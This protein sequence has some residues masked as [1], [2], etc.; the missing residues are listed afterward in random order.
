MNR[1]KLTDRVRAFIDG[2]SGETFDELA[3]AIFREQAA[4]S[5]P[6]ANLV[7]HHRLDPERIVD[8]A[9][10]PP[11]PV[12][13]F[14]QACVTS[15]PETIAAPG[16]ACFHS[17]GTTGSETSRHFLDPDALGVY[18]HSLRSGYRLA[19]PESSHLPVV[20]LARTPWDAPHSSLSHML[21][22]LVADTGGEFYDI[23][24]GDESIPGLKQR[25]EDLRAPVVVFGTAFAWV[26]LFDHDPDWTQ[27]LPA[28]SVVVETGGT[29]GRSREILPEQLYGLF[30]DRLG[31]PDG[32]CVSEYGM[33]ELTSQYWGFGVGGA[34]V[35]PPWLRAFARDP[36]TDQ[37]LPAGEAGV[38]CYV[39]LANVHT[40][41]AM[42]T[43]DWGSVDAAGR[44]HLI[45]RAPGAPIRGCSLALEKWPEL[46]DPA[47]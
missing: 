45:G 30:R 8:S 4:I 24:P 25:L 36:F 13:V 18:E 5:R 19:L 10:I 37:V 14:R 23:A 28:G 35:A 26:H 41:V 21:G 12:G 47:G 7:A 3:V 44:V 39:D 11:M 32:R 27:T 22:C 29:K 34:K 16:S 46:G 40:A 38:L 2:H 20:A 33:C 15:R 43:G 6:W 17:S 9:A 42:R 31:V 1:P